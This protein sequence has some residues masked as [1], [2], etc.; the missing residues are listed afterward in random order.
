MKMR[1]GGGV[2][3]KGRGSAEERRVQDG[4]WKTTIDFCMHGIERGEGWTGSINGEGG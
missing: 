2:T 1:E 4:G 3:K